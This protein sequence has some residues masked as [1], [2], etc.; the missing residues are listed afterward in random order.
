MYVNKCVNTAEANLLAIQDL[1]MP[2]SEA[3]AKEKLAV[4][5][6]LYNEMGPYMMQCP[7]FGFRAVAAT[8]EIV[9]HMKR[10]GMIQA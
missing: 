2:E 5:D 4:I 9:A 7:Q 6:I 8:E 1:I 3:E 10:Q